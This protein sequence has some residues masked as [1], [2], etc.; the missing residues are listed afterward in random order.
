[1]IVSRAMQKKPEARFQ[2]AAQLLEALIGLHDFLIRSP[3]ARREVRRTSQR[4]QLTFLSCSLTSIATAAED[5]DEDDESISKFNALC[6]EIINAHNGRLV[7][8][9]GSR[10][11]ASFG[12][13]IAREGD[14]ERAVRAGLQIVQAV[15]RTLGHQGALSHR[16]RVGIHTGLHSSPL[17]WK[18]KPTMTRSLSVIQP[19]S[20]PAGF[21]ISSTLDPW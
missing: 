5:P 17:R 6:S 19:T 7:A 14:A 9:F 11:L 13:P 21:S 3:Q 8:V 18:A 16:V 10:V 20:S 12:H 4:R 2:T 15:P 1:M